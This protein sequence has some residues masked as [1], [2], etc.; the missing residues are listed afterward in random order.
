MPR[1]APRVLWG[2]QGAPQEGHRC[3]PLA[4]SS[5]LYPTPARE[6]AR[7]PQ[8]ASPLTQNRGQAP[9]PPVVLE[10]RRDP[11][12]RDGAAGPQPRG[13]H[14]QPEGFPASRLPALHGPPPRPHLS[15]LSSC[16]CF[17]VFLSASPRPRPRPPQEDPPW[18][19][20]RR[21]R[22]PAAGSTA[23]RKGPGAR[24]TPGAVVP[25]GG[26][27]E[28]RGRGG[29]GPP[30]SR[31]AVAAKALRAA[32]PSAFR[33]TRA[34]LP[35]CPSLGAKK[36]KTEPV[37]TPARGSAGLCCV[38]HG[39]RTRA[40]G[41]ARPHVRSK[42]LLAACERK[43]IPWLSVRVALPRGVP[44]PRGRQWLLRTQHGPSQADKGLVGGHADLTHCPRVALQPLLG[45]VPLLWLQAWA[46][47]NL[48]PRLRWEA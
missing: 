19:P 45:S 39:E 21:H 12:R 13:E 2:P 47:R 31:W 23:R 20:A 16:F 9:Q 8:A 40:S 10:N 32:L 35:G 3:A 29:G 42:H 14:P 43:K 30:W 7:L 6:A 33:T 44:A 27:P 1:R 26:G 4:P 48:T 34:F 22:S 17:F 37:R 36:W 41:I 24:C 5:R 25:A 46:L 15:P 38:G 11:R 18:P 28:G